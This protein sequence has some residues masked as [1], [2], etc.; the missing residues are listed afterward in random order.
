MLWACSG[1]ALDMLLACT[2]YYLGILWPCSWH[3]GMLWARSA[4]A[5]SSRN[6]SCSIGIR[7]EDAKITK[8]P[9]TQRATSRSLQQTAANVSC[10]QQSA[11]G[12]SQQQ[13]ASTRSSSSSSQP[14]AANNGHQQPA[15]SSILQARGETCDKACDCVVRKR[16]GSD[17]VRVGFGTGA[18]FQQ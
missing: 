8:T 5:L 15:A 1:H 16:S 2:G 3:V 10:Q 11:A 14:G 4:H 18:L 9:A 6:L 7:A 13:P 12:N 17:D